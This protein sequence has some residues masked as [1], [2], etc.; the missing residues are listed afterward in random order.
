VSERTK[1]RSLRA[2]R[3]VRAYLAANGE[4]PA[5]L[6]ASSEE[7]A[8][9]YAREA[10]VFTDG[11]VVHLPSRGAPYGDVFDPAVSRVGRRQRALRSLRAARVVVAGP[12]AFM[13]RTPLYEPMELAAGTEIELDSTLE[14]LVV[15]GYER[16]DRVSRPGEFTVRGGI[17]D[18]FP[19]SRRSPVRVEWWGDEVESVRAVSLATQRVVRELEAVTVYAARE[20]DLAGLAATDGEMPEEARRGVRV[21]GL[22]RLLLELNPVSPRTM[23]PEDVEVWREE[24]QEDVPAGIEGLV[25]ELYDGGMPDPDVEFSLGEEGETISAPPVAGFADTLREAARRLDALVEDGLA[26]FVACSSRGEARRTVYAFGEIHRTMRETARV[27]AD[28]PPG[29]YALPGEVEEGFTYPEGGVAVFRRDSLLGRRREARRAGGRSLAS[30]ADLKVG[31][32][33]VH[34]MQGI[35]R[36]EGLVAQE[37]LGSTRDYMQVSYRGGDTLFVPYEQ[38]EL[39]HKYVGG[40]GA[41]L[42]KLGGATWAQVTDR[43]RKRV[44][45]LAGELLR[46]HAARASAPGFAFPEDGEWERELEESFP[47][48]ETPD[49]E[50]AINAVKSDMQRPHPMDRLVCG[51]VGFGKTEVSVRAA[52]KAALAGKQTMMLAPTTILVQQHERTFKERL[53]SYAVRVE[54]LSRFTLPADRRRIL[55]DFQAGEVD[56]LVGTHALLGSEI[57]PR[58]LGLVVVD[59]E[60][61]FG[62][63]HKERIK[64]YKTSVDVLTLTATPIPR[65]MQMGLASL[66]DISVIETPP[67]GRRSILTHVGPYDEDLVKHAIEREVARGGQTFFVHNRVESIDEVAE[68]LRELLPGVRFVTAHGQMPERALEGVMKHFL[69]GLADV[70]VT[71]TIVE[72]GLDV[73]TANTLIVDRSDAMGLAQLYQLRG[74]IGRSTEQAYAYLFAPLGATV[75]SQKRLEALMDFTELGSGFAIAMRD[76]EIRGAGNLLG[77][78]Q[79]GH[80]AAVGFEMYLTLLEEAVAAARGEPQERREERPV[81]VE[82]TLDAYLPPGY[83][84]DEI[85]RVDLYR[86]ASGLG[87]LAEVED[88]AEELVDRFGALPEP[89]RNLLGLSRV[90]LLA[91]EVGA[92]SVTYRSDN[93]TITGAT[94]GSADPALIRKATGGTVTTR[95]GRISLRAPGSNPLFLAED[96]LR[97]LARAG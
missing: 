88:L 57:R 39:L 27:D 79:S 15:L 67:A 86:R 44:K 78:E 30:F 97:T 92:T 66:R 23:L 50:S 76:L 68:R 20:G 74:R 40:D 85:E 56:V 38:M 75:E 49:Q 8:E 81:I 4:R 2:P 21:P 13:E 32:L 35:G 77:A 64:E 24:P 9:R 89:A 47:Y 31:D 37:V 91:R 80:I 29:L 62:V 45:A 90:K 18:V 28:L 71:T 73:A 3:R 5:L 22:D 36:F 33:V 19:S 11:P 96:S 95:T 84:M 41:R 58:D 94:V 53:D 87:S 93:L 34:A 17:V 72:S 42:D 10:E 25:H 43:V 1:T 51:D 26:V 82:L 46:L 70:L 52:F 60:Q 61:R 83:V 12:L 65:T 7:A 59:E 6:L 14:R 55:A 48:Q 16:V 54:S 63:R 69:D